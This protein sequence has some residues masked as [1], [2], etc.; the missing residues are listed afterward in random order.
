MQRNL[1]PHRYRETMSSA[2]RRVE[3]IAA[4]DAA[5]ANLAVEFNGMSE[6]ELTSRRL[7]L[8]HIETLIAKWVD[9]GCAVYDVDAIL[10]SVIEGNCGVFEL[11]AGLFKGIT[12]VH[13]GRFEWLQTG[14][15]SDEFVEGLYLQEKQHGVIEILEL[16]FVCGGQAWDGLE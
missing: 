15:P 7:S 11:E 3:K 10:G 13:F 8:N 9:D 4:S 1:H 14:A 2:L 5:A 16:T 12:F 6:A